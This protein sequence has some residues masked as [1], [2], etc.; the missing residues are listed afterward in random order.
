MI[1][2][3]STI[4]RAKPTGPGQSNGD[5]GYDRG[6][7]ARRSIADGG[8]QEFLLAERHGIGSNLAE[9]KAK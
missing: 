6:W 9:R 4:V 2:N 3:R 8:G 7:N 5:A 1:A